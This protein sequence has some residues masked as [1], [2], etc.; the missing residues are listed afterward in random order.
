M[1]CCVVSSS[2]VESRISVAM[3]RRRG[4]RATNVSNQKI[5][6]LD[7]VTRDVTLCTT[8]AQDLDLETGGEPTAGMRPKVYRHDNP[9][10]ILSSREQRDEIFFSHTRKVGISFSLDFFLACSPVITSF[11]RLDSE[12]ENRL[13][14]RV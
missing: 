2:A 3:V 11:D 13:G 8:V 12:A 6:G 9:G 1:G 10:H 5:D 14:K 4:L 7:H